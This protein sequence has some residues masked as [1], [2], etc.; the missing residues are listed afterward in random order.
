MSKPK[1]E[2]RKFIIS[3]SSMLIDSSACL[4]AFKN[5]KAAFVKFDA[6]FDDSFAD[7]WAAAID[8]ANDLS[9]DDDTVD[10]QS[11]YTETVYDTMAACREIFQDIKYYIQKAFPTRKAVWKEFGF[12]NYN[13]ARNVVPKMNAFMSVLN[14]KANKYK[15][16][17]M[18]ANCPAAMID[19]IGILSQTLVDA[20]ITQSEVK[21][22]RYSITDDRVVKLNA[23]WT[24][25]QAVAK[26]A[27][28]IYRKNYGK[29]KQYLLP[30]SEETNDIY[31]IKGLLKDKTTGENL[32][33]VQVSVLNHPSLET[34]TDSNGNFGFA[35]MEDGSYTL[36]FT[37]AGYE[38][39]AVTIK[40][41]GKKIKLKAEMEKIT[42]V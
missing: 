30:A 42:A 33:K 28:I 31:T 14:K 1:K 4:K 12:A 17:L 36:I 16:Q 41:S 22:S 39:V 32:E 19:Q 6:D 38:T 27:K 8:I 25:R 3:D 15:N 7:N 21:N 20:K 23:V 40:L 2:K 9:T 34:I 35:D 29:Y 18:A 5:D 26:A 13:N 24:F 37:L 10:V 11:G